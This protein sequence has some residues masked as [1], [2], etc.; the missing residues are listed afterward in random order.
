MRRINLL[1]VQ[2]FLQANSIDDLAKEPY[3]IKVKDYPEEGLVMLNYDQ[4]ESPKHDPIIKECRGLILDRNTYE[5]VA[6][7]FDRFFNYGECPESNKYNIS[8][9]TI[10]EKVDGSLITCYYYRDRWNV[11]TRGM[12]FAEGLTSF[13]N[14]FRSVFDKAF[15]INKLDSLSYHN[16][17]CFIFELVSP[18]TRVVTPYSTYEVKLLTVRNKHNGNELIDVDNW[19]EKLKVTQP[20]TF[21]FN[22]LEEVIK[23]SKELPAL[24]EGYVCCWENGATNYRLKIKNPSYLAIAHMRDNG[25][26]SENRVIKLVMENDHEEYLIHFEED[27]KLFQPYIDAYSYMIEDINKVW[28]EAKDITSQKEFALIVKEL[29]ISG[30]LFKKR[31]GTIDENGYGKDISFIDIIREM[32]DNMKERLLKSYIK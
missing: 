2:Q 12:A 4:I 23:M 19:A 27:Q 1:H 7:S 22:S 24:E 30:V 8:N 26:V 20:K 10:L 21:K 13:G 16:H 14:T 31:K 28:D 3:F 9:A 17:L 25:I 5:V 6:R 29:P 32:T 15:D 11:S 18:E